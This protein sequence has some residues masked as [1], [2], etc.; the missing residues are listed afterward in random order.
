MRVLVADD[1]VLLR[2]GLLRLLDEAGH[3][4]VA[5][6]GDAP[7]LVP[8]AVEHRPEV[9]IVDIRMPPTMTDDGLRAAVEARAAVPTM[10]VL[11]LSAYVEKSYADALLS[12]GRGGVGYLLKDRVSSL[13]TLTDALT[14]IHGGGTVLDPEV[15]AQLLVS[16]RTDPL[17]RLT[18]R[19]REVL[20]LMA[21]GRSNAAIAE[22]LVI[23]PGAVEKHVGNIFVKIDLVD[24]GADNRR[25]LAVLA[26]LKRR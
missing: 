18:P 11:L 8:A 6:V 14:T 7:S 9:A 19:E 24:A 2:E 25:V 23:S 3:T 15:V 21:E 5:A 17:D 22:R 12:D 10:G 20:A 26:W 16:R 4:V 1:S 13:E